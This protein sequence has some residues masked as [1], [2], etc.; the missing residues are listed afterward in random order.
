MALTRHAFQLES[1]PSGLLCGLVALIATSAM[2]F[3]GSGLHPPWWLT[4]AP[5]PVLLISR[6]VS[7]RTAFLLS[8][9]S[10]CLSGLNMWQYFLRALGMPLL[11]IIVF[12]VIP[13]C[14]FGL[15]VLLFRSL[16]SQGAL[17]KA[18]L[19]FPT[20]WVT[21]EYLNNIASRHGTFPN[22]GY[23]QM[24]FLPILQFTSV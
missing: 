18:S 22:F 16:L 7:R 3:W 21:V 20:F 11:L 10:W 6:Y 13:A 17:W 15:G 4:F 19:A 2:L 5:L 1:A 23:T 12:T 8:V 24:D 9:L 14:L